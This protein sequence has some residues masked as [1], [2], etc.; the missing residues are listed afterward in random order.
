VFQLENP[1]IFKILLFR[2]FQGI[3]MGDNETLICLDGVKKP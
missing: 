1:N 3:I 2:R